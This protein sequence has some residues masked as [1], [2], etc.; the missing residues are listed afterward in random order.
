MLE[1]TYEPVECVA[2][3]CRGL[4]GNINRLDEANCSSTVDVFIDIAV[5][6]GLPW[7]RE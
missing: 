7:G 1:H 4:K 5:T 3:P 2:R 6:Q